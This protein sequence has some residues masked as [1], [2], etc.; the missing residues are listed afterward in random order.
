MNEKPTKGFSWTGPDN[1]FQIHDDSNVGN[2]WKTQA[3]A[4]SCWI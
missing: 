4:N 1:F 3:G 2:L